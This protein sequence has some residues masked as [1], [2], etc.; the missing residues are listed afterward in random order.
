MLTLKSNQTPAQRV[1]LSKSTIALGAVLTV[2]LAAPTGWYVRHTLEQSESPHPYPFSLTEGTRGEATIERKIAFY[3][4]RIQRN[5]GDGLDRAALASAYLEMA[6]ATGDDRWYLLAE[7]SAQQS[8]ANLPFS[9]DGAV[10]VLAEIAEAKHDFA[11]AIRLAE[12]ASGEDALALI[13]TAKLAMGE[14]AAAN[15]TAETLVNLTPSLGSLTLRALTRVAQ[16]DREGALRDFQQAIA[17]EEPAD[18]SGSAWARTLLGRFYAQQGDH[19]L[20]E[21]LYREALVIDPNNTLARLQL[22]VLKT[23]LGHYRAAERHYAQVNDPVA[24]HGLARVRSLRGVATTDAWDTAESALREHIDENALGHRRDLAHLLLERGHGEDVPEAIAL[25]Q[26]E[27][28]NRRDAATL[29]LL[30]WALTRGDRWQEAQQ[31]IQEA[32]DHGIRDAGIFYRAGV[33][34][35]ALKHPQQAERYFQ[36][37]Q[38]ADPTFDDQ[39]RHRLGLVAHP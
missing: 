26:T 37:A 24:L 34:E 16:G 33:I 30:A 15:A 21:P 27:V 39:V 18:P 25:L 29:D 22:A 10:L 20:A 9:N 36:Q 2:L 14:V 3:E 1:Q 5:P 4:G 32:L 11:E 8:L 28:Q 13:V 17:A 7:Q 35:A 23:R 38:E 12:Q 31:V 19:D 6:H